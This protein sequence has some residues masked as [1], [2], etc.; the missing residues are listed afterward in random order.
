ML[1][2]PLAQALGDRLG[3]CSVKQSIGNDR[4][5]AIRPYSSRDCLYKT[6]FSWVVVA[7]VFNAS[8]QESEAGRSL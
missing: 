8:T 2:P 7:H 3:R 4:G 6:C 1:P 5:I